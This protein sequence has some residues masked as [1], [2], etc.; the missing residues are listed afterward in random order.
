MADQLRGLA[1]SSLTDLADMLHS[2]A[3]GA[4]ALPATHAMPFP[5]IARWYIY[6]LLRA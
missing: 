6:V 2:K 5:M 3:S 1:L 4:L